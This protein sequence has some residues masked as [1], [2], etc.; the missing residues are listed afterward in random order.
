LAHIDL[1]THTTASDGSLSPT[2]LVQLAK[3]QGLAALAVTDHDSVEAIPEVTAAGEELGIRVIPGI[4]ISSGY[5]G[6]ELHIHGYYI[7]HNVPRLK[8]VLAR[9]ITSRDDRNPK[10]IERLCALGLNL[11]YEDVKTY[12]GAATIGRPHI[13]QILV[14]KGYATSVA[15]AFDRYLADD[16]PAYVARNLPSVQEVITLIRDIGGVAVLAHPMYAGRRKPS[17]DQHCADLQGFGL[18]GLE[19]L[20]SSHTAQQT[21]R[22]RSI[23]RE[24]G[25]LITGGSDFHGD[26]KPDVL[27]GTGYGNLKVPLELLETLEAAAKNRP[28]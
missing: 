28:D 4:E 22:F 2:E 24:H 15:D 7:N 16:G 8:P 6:I 11:T 13:A 20:Y 9:C 17:I 12:A 14:R 25:L 23:A 10:I 26:S 1:H 27:V 3:H 18:A 5:Q 19:T 21:D